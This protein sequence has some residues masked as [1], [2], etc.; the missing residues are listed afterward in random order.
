MELILEQ[1]DLRPEYQDVAT[2]VTK[3]KHFSMPAQEA[4]K[5]V[6]KGKFVRRDTYNVVYPQPDVKPITLGPISRWQDIRMEIP[7]NKPAS[8]DVMARVKT[9]NG[10]AV[11]FK[12][13]GEWTANTKNRA[14][15]I[16]YSLA[17]HFAGENGGLATH[18]RVAIFSLAA[19]VDIVTVRGAKITQKE[20]EILTAGYEDGSDEDN[21]QKKL[22][23]R[24]PV[25]T[26]AILSFF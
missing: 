17:Q 9:A 24:F 12:K 2:S 14:V 5:I 7:H 13:D 4:L 1:S 16:G 23:E 8:D 18:Q 22:G 15:K 26:K 20:V 3:W 19:D 11:F 21:A 10:E 6:G 25:I